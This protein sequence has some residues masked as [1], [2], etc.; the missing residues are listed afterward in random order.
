MAPLGLPRLLAGLL[1][2]VPPGLGVAGNGLNFI[3]YGAES[4]LMGGADTAVARDAA[5]PPTLRSVHTLGWR[6]QWVLA[7]GAAFHISALTT[8]RAGLNYGRNPIPARYTSPLLNAVG[9]KHL[10]F[11]LSRKLGDE[12]T[13]A[14]GVEYQ[15]R[16]SV[17]YSNPELPFGPHA[18]ARN[19]YAALHVMVSRRW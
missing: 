5:A 11:G 17:R 8:V 7:V 13:L 6:D 18:E 9:E 1:L 14:A 12:Y 4:S 2:C 10:T 16:N 3:G 15:L 19:E